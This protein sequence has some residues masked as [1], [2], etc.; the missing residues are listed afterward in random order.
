MTTS[1]IVFFGSYLQVLRAFADTMQVEMVVLETRRKEIEIIEFCKA[2]KIKCIEVNEID[3]LENLLS[4]TM[5]RVGVV[6]SFGLL[7]KQRHIDWFKALFNF[8]PG[9]V[10]ANRGR[11]PLPNAILNGF[12]TMSLTVHQITDERIDVG[13]FVSKVELSID[14]TRDYNDNYSRLL[15]AL[16]FLAQDLCKALMKGGVPS[17][18]FNPKQGS[19][20]PPLTLDILKKI[21]ESKNLMEWYR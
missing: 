12:R 3:E 13:R 19:Y 15:S 5:C 6:A 18:K 11:H 17:F 1:S 7:F 16:D 20:F 21:M 9:C 2:M 10:Y 14:Y 4:P 8:H